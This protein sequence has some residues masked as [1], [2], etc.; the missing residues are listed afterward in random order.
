MA[1]ATPEKRLTG[2]GVSAGIAIGPARTFHLRSLDIHPRSI[3]DPAAELARYDEAVARARRDLSVLKKQ[4]ADEIG[5]RQAA[6]FDAHIGLLDDVALRP[7]IERR[8]NLE[9]LN[10]EYVVNEL[11]AGYAKLLEQVEDPAFRERSTDLVDVGRRILS[12]LLGEKLAS[13]EHIDAPC[14]VVA[15]ELAP[16]ETATMDMTNTLGLATDAGGP[17]SHMAIIARAFEIPSVVGLRHLGDQVEDG[18]TLIVDGARGFVIMHPSK[19]T[20]AKYET[21][22]RR[23]AE[24][25]AALIEATGDGPCVTLDGAEIPTYAN[26]ELLAET[27]MS[28]Q[29]RCQGI[30]LYRTEFLY[31]DREDLPTEEE[32]FAEY[33]KVMESMA[34]LPV[35]A[36]TLDVGGDKDMPLLTHDHETN[37]QLGWRSIRLCLD[38][39]DIFKAQLRALLRA[40]VYGDLRIMF[41]MITSL[42]QFLEARKMLD[43]VK[44]DLRDR[45]VKFNDKV[46]VGS[47]VEV[48]AAALIAD[49]LA[50]ECDFLSIG[51]NDLI[52]YCLAV[53]RSNERTAH[54][55]QPTHLAVLRMLKM[56]LDAAN[57]ANIPCSVCGEMAGDPTLTELLL[58][59]GFRSLSM[60]SASLPAVRA[61]IANTHLANAKRF[62]RKVLGLATTAEIRELIAQRN[63]RRDT[64]N[65]IRRG[66]LGGI[67]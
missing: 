41:P 29:A 13:L 36:R 12:N 17:T 65:R 31:M 4:T 24:I 22:K 58:G 56:T 23:L 30:G 20:L 60:S 63:T 48:P 9:N 1:K 49:Q 37:P 19:S 32:Q 21:E 64:V 66:D 38:R 47:M 53:D 11:I 61:E 15:H 57:D 40:S 55:Y 44:D 35:T 26:I 18:D 62:A 59:M 3:E 8:L 25:R 46:P 28:R 34:P 67:S 54:L 5:E 52:Q 51:T 2:I 33:R 27:Q 39:P 14:I 6:I 43:E 42:E 45:G 16:S 10:V 7:E 50:R